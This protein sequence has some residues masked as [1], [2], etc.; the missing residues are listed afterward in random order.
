MIFLIVNSVLIRKFVRSDKTKMSVP[1]T[2]FR[3]VDFSCWLGVPI[4]FILLPMSGFCPSTLSVVFPAS[5]MGFILQNQ[6]SDYLKL[7]YIK[8]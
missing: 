3:N 8:E 4:V 2:Y 6:V 7:V 5:V 1:K